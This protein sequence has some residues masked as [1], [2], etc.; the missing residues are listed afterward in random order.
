MDGFVRARMTGE[1]SYEGQVALEVD[2]HNLLK[3]RLEDTASSFPN[4]PC[5]RAEEGSHAVNV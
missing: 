2:F 3:H 4:S 5:P 1:D